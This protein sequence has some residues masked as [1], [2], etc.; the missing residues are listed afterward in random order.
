MKDLKKLSSKPQGESQEC[1]SMK[2]VETKLG[3]NVTFKWKKHS[4][5]LEIHTK[6]QGKGQELLMIPMRNVETKLR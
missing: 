1:L 3:K 2:N 5:T 6:P 4:K